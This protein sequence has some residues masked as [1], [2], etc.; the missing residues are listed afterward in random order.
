MWD[1]KELNFAR[2][3]IALTEFYLNYV[4]CKVNY[5][6]M[7]IFLIFSFTLT[8]WDVKVVLDKVSYK[9]WLSFTLTMWDVK[10]T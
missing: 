3:Y 9:L 10:P 6:L 4:G 7:R 8:M 2:W 5:G 1:V